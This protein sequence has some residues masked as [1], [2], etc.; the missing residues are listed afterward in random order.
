[1]NIDGQ[2][3][4]DGVGSHEQAPLIMRRAFAPFT[5]LKRHPF[6]VKAHFRRSLVLTYALPQEILKLL[7]PPGLTLDTYDGFGF[8]AI[9]M[10]QTERLRPAFLPAALGQNFFLAG[11]RIFVRFKTSSGRTLRGLRILRSYT[12]RPL[13]VFA[14][15]QLTHY[16]YRLARVSIH[17][18][19]G[20][21]EIKTT[22]PAGEADLYVRADL[23][24]APVTLPEGSPFADLHAARLFAGPLPYTF[25]YEEPTHSIVLIEG[26]RREWKPKLV[27]VEV[28]KNNFF[29]DPIFGGFTPIL[30]NAFQ[31]ENIDYLWKRGIRERLPR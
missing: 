2:I 30:A 3:T 29:N 5:W 15:N 24:D 8:V 22:T 11:Y 25:D 26:V 13:M 21:L 7:L 27:N 1:M 10:V 9:A 18:T 6:P 28:A 19:P 14:G 4:L 31:I 16:H 12:D 17:E 20:Q 23:T